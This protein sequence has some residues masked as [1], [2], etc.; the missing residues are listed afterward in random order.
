MTESISVRYDT[1]V[2]S[3]M[4]DLEVY[5]LAH[6]VSSRDNKPFLEILEEAINLPKPKP[7]PTLAI[8][9]DLVGLRNTPYQLRKGQTSPQERIREKQIER[10]DKDFTDK[11]IDL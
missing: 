8:V 9:M 2:K 6:V 3:I 7:E 4:E 5:Q 10:L 11:Y 1:I